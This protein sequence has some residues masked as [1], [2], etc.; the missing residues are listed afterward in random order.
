MFSITSIIEELGKPTGN[1]MM[2]GKLTLPA[3]HVLNNLCQS[4]KR[5][6]SHLRIPFTKCFEGGNCQLCRLCEAG[7]RYHLCGTGDV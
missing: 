2:E 4:K 7:G 5:K 3:L 1:D 6:N